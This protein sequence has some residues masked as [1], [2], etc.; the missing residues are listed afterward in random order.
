MILTSSEYSD[1]N[2]MLSFQKISGKSYALI[3]GIPAKHHYD[4]IQAFDSKKNT[5][6]HVHLILL[7]FMFNSRS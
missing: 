7:W 2:L 3:P 5:N 4:S 6:I 1:R